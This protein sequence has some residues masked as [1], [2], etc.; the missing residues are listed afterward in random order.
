L[1]FPAIWLGLTLVDYSLNNLSREQRS[2]GQGMTTTT[3][4]FH[5]LQAWS[6]LESCDPLVLKLSMYVKKSEDGWKKDT[7]PFLWFVLTG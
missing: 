3:W 6:F 1:V 7:R 2:A 5:V 4:A